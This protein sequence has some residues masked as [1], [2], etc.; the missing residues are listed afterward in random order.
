MFEYSVLLMSNDYTSMDYT[1]VVLADFGMAA[2]RA[3]V[4][5]CDAVLD[6]LHGTP[7]FAAPELLVLA[8]RSKAAGSNNTSKKGEV[9]RKTNQENMRRPQRQRSSSSSSS[10]RNVDALHLRA[11]ASER[12][13]DNSRANLTPNAKNAARNRS[14]SKRRHSLSGS[15]VGDETVRRSVGVGGQSSAISMFGQN[16]DNDRDRAR[17]SWNSASSPPVHAGGSDEGHAA[18]VHSGMSADEVESFWEEHEDKYTCLVDIWAA[19]AVLYVMLSAHTP[20]CSKGN[21][22]RMVKRIIEGRYDFRAELWREVSDDAKDMIKSMMVVL[23]HDRPTASQCL[24][25]PFLSGRPLEH[26]TEHWR[27]S[28]PFGSEYDA[29]GS[30]LRYIERDQWR[31]ASLERMETEA[32]GI[33]SPKMPSPLDRHR[34]PVPLCT[35]LSNL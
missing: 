20:F 34:G 8:K 16:N 15:E 24:S 26:E 27:V 14:S 25:H 2:H 29:Q 5:S 30:S 22:P 33:E 28:T 31:T 19:G 6:T 3:G 17:M 1:R 18:R 32:F 13:R 7:E 4:A 23:P 9:Q 12:G 10:P 21:I 11:P 35:T